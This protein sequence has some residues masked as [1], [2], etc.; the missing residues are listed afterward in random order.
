M[1]SDANPSKDA[2]SDEDEAFVLS[3]S[4]Q[5]SFEETSK[6]GMQTKLRELETKHERF[7]SL[8]SQHKQQI[9]A[10]IGQQNFNEL[11]QLYRSKIHV[12]PT[13]TEGELGDEEQEEIEAFVYSKLPTEHSDVRSRQL[14][15]VMYKLLHLEIEIV[16]IQKAA[17][18]LRFNLL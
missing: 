17:T 14:I 4:S 9:I 11:Y 5:D 2:S 1:Y 10:A 8:I 13:Q 15:Y 7:N 16:D 3:D 18:A 12:R 6:E